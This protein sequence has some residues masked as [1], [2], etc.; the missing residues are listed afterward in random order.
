[1]WLFINK[2]IATK[3]KY[4]IKGSNVDNFEVHVFL[5]ININV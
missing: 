5:F 4:Q 1:M 2:W 3:F